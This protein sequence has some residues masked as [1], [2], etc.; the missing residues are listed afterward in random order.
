MFFFLF[1]FSSDLPFECVCEKV[2]FAE[3]AS[4]VLA[5]KALS[6]C[7]YRG[8]E[9]MERKGYEETR[10]IHAKQAPAALCV[11]V[12]VC[13]SVILSLSKAHSIIGAGLYMYF[14]GFAF[15]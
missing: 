10:K 5:Q 2:Y 8:G 6:L 15:L 7:V 4:K 13:V 14:T 11:P 12:R 9:S 1:F 3:N